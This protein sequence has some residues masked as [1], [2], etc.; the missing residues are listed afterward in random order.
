LPGD[1]SVPI[2][3]EPFE[4]TTLSVT[5]DLP[6]PEPT[7]HD[8]VIRELRAQREPLYAI[9]DAARDP[10][11]LTRL[12]D[13]KEEHQSLY[14]G[15]KGNQLSAAAPYLV[16]MPAGSASLQ[17][18]AR[19]GWGESWGVYL[20][21]DKPFRELRKHLRHFL[22]VELDGRKKVYFRFYDPRVLRVFLPTC[23]ASELTQFLGPIRCYLFEGAEPTEMR[24]A[25]V[26][27]GCMRLEN[28][29]LRPAGK[30]KA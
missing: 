28:R 8:R 4:P 15:A 23:D 9:L 22:M 10:L 12:L 2:V 1:A 24:I 11:V 14:E 26:D 6:V 29:S 5:V 13:C 21:S 17:T 19:A 3:A 18:I 30:S 16:S 20:T 27:Y 7:L 25:S